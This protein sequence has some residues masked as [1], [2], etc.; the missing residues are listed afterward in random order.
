MELCQTAIKQHT[1]YRLI[2]KMKIVLIL[3]TYALAANLPDNQ[4]FLESETELES[5][6]PV[7]SD[8]K[9]KP[10]AIVHKIL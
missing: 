9:E 1:N 10:V 6:P 7:Y 2:L 5:A 4:S 3:F 8:F